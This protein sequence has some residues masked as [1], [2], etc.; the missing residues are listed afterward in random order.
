MS[1][2][3]S[4]RLSIVTLAGCRHI[5]SGTL[6]TMAYSCGWIQILVALYV[7]SLATESISWREERALGAKKS[8]IVGSDVNIGS[9]K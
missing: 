1:T 3:I 4:S 2:S 5:S 7:G 9:L 8:W 6:L